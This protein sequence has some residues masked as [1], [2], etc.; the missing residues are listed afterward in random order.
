MFTSLRNRVGRRYSKAAVRFSSLLVLAIVSP[1]AFAQEE[2]QE[3][4]IRDNS[5]LV[6]EAF[7][8]EQGVVQ[9]IFNWVPSWERGEAHTNEFAM[10]FTQEWPLGSQLHQLSYTLPMLYAFERIPGQPDFEGQGFGDMLLNYRFQALAGNP[11]GW[12]AAP[13][14]SLIL[15]TG[16]ERDGLGDGELGYQLN[17][18]LS[19]EF[20]H[21]VLHLN[22]GLFSSHLA[23]P[24]YV[25][26]TEVT[27]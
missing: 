10:V 5:F 16:D 21:W 7:N 15:P 19:R 23:I 26:I 3:P 4:G 1:A 6:E 13:R 9:H 8:Q 17:L 24:S 25:A 11:G 2:G 20:E 22:A 27:S 12:W 14:A 18:P